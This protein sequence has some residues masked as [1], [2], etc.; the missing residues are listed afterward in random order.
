MNSNDY[1]A[2]KKIRPAVLLTIFLLN[3]SAAKITDV[4]PSILI[5]YKT[6]GYHHSCIPTGIEAIKKL[7]Q[8]NGFSVNA[9]DDS[10]SLR[11]IT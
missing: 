10:S 4:K 2:M 9:T 5:F 8:Q 3:I 7:G 11:P 6:N 1:Y